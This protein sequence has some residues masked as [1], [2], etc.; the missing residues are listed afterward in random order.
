MCLHVLIYVL[1]Y[2]CICNQKREKF[3]E[4]CLGN[5]LYFPI[6]Y[7]ANLATMALFLSNSNRLMRPGAK[8][9]V[10]KCLW[11]SGHWIS[12][13]AMEYIVIHCG[14]PPLSSQVCFNEKQKCQYIL[15]KF[16]IQNRLKVWVLFNALR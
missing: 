3:H 7:S 15:L 12:Y 9:L 11:L 6:R 4:G 13:R 10:I 5:L 14:F 2:L 1:L 8:E 16:Q